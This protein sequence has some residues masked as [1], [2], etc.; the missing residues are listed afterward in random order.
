MDGSDLILNGEIVLDGDVMPHHWCELVGSNCF[1]AR[2]VREA[3]AQFSGDVTV[4][5]NSG[6]G[7]PFEGEAIRAALE[8]HQGAVTCVVSGHAASAASFLIM[9]AARIEM[10]AGSMFMIHDPSSAFFGTANEHRAEAQVLDTMSA[11]YAGV[12]AARSGQSRGDVL[13]MMAATTWFGAEDTVAAG[14]A[15]GLVAE[16]VE[17]AVPTARAAAMAAHRETLATLRRCAAHFNS[18]PHQVGTGSQAATVGQPPQ[19]VMAA[20]Q[21][22]MMDPEKNDQV[23]ANEAETPQERTPPQAPAATMRAPDESAIT[24]RAVEAERSRQRDIRS[25]SAPFVTAGQLTQ[26]Q[27]DEVIDQGVTASE[28]GNRLMALMAPAP[29]Q[30]DSGQRVHV[31]RDEGETRM[32]GMICAMMRD[33]EGPGSDFRGMRVR[34]LAMELAGPG[35]GFNETEAVRRGMM[36]TRMMGGAHGVSDFSYITTEV[37]NRSLMRDYDRRG[38]NWNIV[39]G[40]P[41]SASD[42]REMHAVRFG[43]DFQLKPVKENGEYESAVLADQAEGLTVERR[44]RDIALTFEAVVGDDMGAFSRIPREFAMAARLMESSMVWGLI[45]TNATLKSDSTALF[46]ANHGN[47]ASSGAAISVTTVGAARKAMW[48]QRAYGAADTDDFL[49]VVPD[50]MLVT[51]AKELAARQ[52]IADITPAKTSDANPF[53]ATLTPYTIPNLGAVAGGSDNAWYLISSDLP[54]VSV[55]YLEGYEAPTVRTIEG[56]N[57]DVVKMNA[58]HIFGAAASEYRGAYKNAGA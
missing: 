25:M 17:L 10:T 43:G 1:S 7:D 58:R 14:F 52:F 11:T 36:S 51:P 3:L 35:R 40:E 8:A 39:T 2:M 12:Y 23:A 6:G 49:E 37:M 53:R 18:A 27:V 26:A 34:R 41:L 47:L 21:E 15:D 56:M 20:T 44:G 54:P 38:A 55:A 50:I 22:S 16:E 32:E 4:R 48:E 9:A 5:I 24:A 42:F 29:H 19:A 28:A 46:H 30:A 45:R 13:A 33:Y 57:P 31:R